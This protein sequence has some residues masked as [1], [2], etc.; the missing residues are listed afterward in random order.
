MKWSDIVGIAAGNGYTLGLRAD[1]TVIGTGCNKQI[2]NEVANWKLFHNIDTLEQE[3]LECQEQHKRRTVLRTDAPSGVPQAPGTPGMSAN[4]AA[5]EAERNRL[6][7]ELPN[8]K[9]LFSGG[10]RKQVEN[11]LAEIEAELKKL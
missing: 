1:G 2:L 5:L 8:I 9:G 10:K 6:Q 3:Q 7:A 4:R 11:R